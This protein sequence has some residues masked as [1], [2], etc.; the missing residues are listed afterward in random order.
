MTLPRVIAALA[1]TLLVAWIVAQVSAPDDLGRN[2][3]L[4]IGSVMCLVLAG[5]NIV[6]Y[7]GNDLGTAVRYALIWGGLLALVALAYTNKA[8]FGF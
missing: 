2:V 4:L 1:V 7:F 6:G 8:S 5:S 3:A